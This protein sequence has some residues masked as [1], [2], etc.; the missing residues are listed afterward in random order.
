MSAD[1]TIAVWDFSGRTALI[2]GAAGDIGR[3]VAVRLAGSGA[4]LS[5][6][7]LPDTPLGEVAAACGRLSSPELVGF[8]F[9]DVKD[10]AAVEQVVGQAASALGPPQLVFNNAG[11]QG[12]FATVDR[13]PSEEFRTVLDVN[14]VGAFNV[15]KSAGA[16]LR[17][18]GLAGSIVNTASMAFA[19]P[20][21]MIAYSA[22]KNA[23]IAM[24][25][26]A[27][28]DLAPIGIRVNAVSPGFIG[29]GRMWRRQT[30][31]QAQVGSQ[32]FPDNPAEVAEEMLRSVPLRRYGSVDEV[33]S[34]VV[35]LLSDEA[36]Y[37]TGVNI[38]IA[39]GA[40]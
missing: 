17:Q 20:P 39:G 25:A 19:G 14:V 3:A 30:E 9:V 23:V 1:R 13:Y 36:S 21:N 31:Q 24:T 28:K 11:V 37:L 22:S 10:A 32:Y 35:F 12:D 18:S 15:L 8:H 16:L 5:L 7:D 26:T 38:E 33:A 6:L 4:A 34:V 2:T 27:A 29:P 40:T